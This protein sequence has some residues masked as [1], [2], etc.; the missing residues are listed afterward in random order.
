MANEKFI[1]SR[2]TK[3]YF[4]NLE[5]APCRNVITILIRDIKKVFDVKTNVVYSFEEA[6][7]IVQYYDSTE[8]ENNEHEQYRYDFVEVENKN[9]LMISGS[10]DL[11]IIYGLLHLSKVYFGIDPF[12]F[13]MDQEVA[14][15]EKIA[16]PMIPYKSRKHSI[17]Y[18]GWFIN[19]EVC[20]IGWTDVYPP[21]KKVWYPVF[22]TILRCNGNMVLPGTDLPKEGVH[23]Q[24]ALDMGLWTTQHHAEPLGAEF[25]LR[26]YPDLDPSFSQYPELFEGLWR[27]SVE[28]NKDS[29][30]IWVLGHRGQGDCPFW[31]N[32]PQFNTPESRGKVISE[33]IAKQYQI[34]CEYVERPVFAT[35]LYGEIM[36]LYAQNH[37]QFPKGI[38]KIWSDNGYGKMVSRRQGNWNPRIPSVPSRDNEGPHGAYYHVTFHDLQASNHLTM[39]GVDPE[40]MVRELSFLTKKTSNEFLLVN[41]GNIKPHIFLLDMIKEFWTDGH[42]SVNDHLLD[43]VT[44]YYNSG[45]ESIIKCMKEYFESAIEYGPN[46]DDRAGDEYYHHPIRMIIKHWMAHNKKPLESFKWAG[47]GDTF[48]KQIIEFMEKNL[49]G[50]ERWSRLY[51]Q[52]E[53]V[54]KTLEERD[55]IIFRDNFVFQVVLHQ[56]GCRGAAAVCKSILKSNEGK[57]IDAFLSA[58]DAIRNFEIGIDWMRKV[59]H[60]RW[61]NFYRADWLTNIKCTIYVVDS[62][63]RYI[64]VL[65][66][67]P[68]F[69]WWYKSKIIPK[70]ER[71]IYLENTQREVFS[72]DE[73][74]DMLSY[75][76]R[77]KV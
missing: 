9:K 4:K 37:I 67:G 68:D 71:N 70:E 41:S 40:I 14:V 76:T 24:L 61:K 66:D 2:S 3:Y 36:E 6:D 72:D 20:L 53:E 44:R 33:V 58:T 51:T 54:L 75:R 32:D 5:S 60:D 16:I 15:K 43:F 28:K 48:E 21:P 19:D 47:S 18:R 25:F 49:K 29:N 56:S 39:L 38:I 17:R 46:S 7:V 13:W 57:Y 1:L 62:L 69:F 34:L 65:G 8:N 31:E 59:E 42:I 77:A 30:M 22:E 35:Y 73:I 52:C 55:R 50:F 12:W 23:L 74:A 11:G 64:R 10:D 27:E 45:Q 63:R 26:S